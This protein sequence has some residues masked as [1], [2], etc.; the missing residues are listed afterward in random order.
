MGKLL[1]LEKICG[2]M[3]SGK[4]KATGTILT[5]AVINIVNVVVMGQYNLNI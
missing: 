1:I 3:K 2:G 4:S 5:V